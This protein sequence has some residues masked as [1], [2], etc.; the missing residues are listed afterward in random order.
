MTT[1]LRPVVT[2]CLLCFDTVSPVGRRCIQVAHVKEISCSSS[3]SFRHAATLVIV[4]ALVTVGSTT[5]AGAD[6][7]ASQAIVTTPLPAGWELCILEGVRAPATQDNITNLDDWQAAEGGSTNNDAAYNPFNTRRMTDANN[8]ELPSTISPN[9]FPAFENWTAGCAA[10][11]ATLLQPNMTPILTALQGGDVS[12]AGIFLSD[13]DASQWC[14]PSSDGTPCYAAEIVASK[15]Q[16]KNKNVDDDA[17]RLIS[18][19]QS[20]LHSYNEDV[21]IISAYETTIDAQDLQLEVLQSEVSLAQEQVARSLRTLRNVVVRDYMTNR[22]EGIG[23]SL[24]PFDTPSEEELLAE[25]YGNMATSVLSNRFKSSTEVLDSRISQRDALSTSIALTKS[26][27]NSIQAV[28]GQALSQLKADLTAINAAGACTANAMTPGGSSN[29]G[30]GTENQV[31]VV[32]LTGCLNV[33][34]P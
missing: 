23:P 19:T 11:V 2:W 15:G 5:Q 12:P 28:Q 14:A 21:S 34:D 20:A 1:S 29:D 33:L 22:S 32:T 30:S 9:G 7:G 8:T 17:L 31:I 24:Q 18:D 10:T 25:I 27:I 16:A 4:F 3:R 13:V 26:S 6:S